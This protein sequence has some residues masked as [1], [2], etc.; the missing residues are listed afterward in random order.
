MNKF[1]THEGLVVPFDKSNID[2]DAIIPKQF[3][4][5][6]KRTGFGPH[7]FDELRYLDYGEPG[8]DHTQRKLNPNFILNQSRYYGASILLTRKNF[9]CG[10]SRE[11]ALWALYEYGFRAIIALSFA[12]IFMNNCFFNGLLP[13]VLS[14][15]E[16]EAL[17]ELVNTSFGLK[18]FINLSEQMISTKNLV[19]KFKIDAFCKYC[20]LNGLDS[21]SS[22]LRYKHKI[23]A[24]EQDYFCKY[25]W[26][27]NTLT[28][29]KYEL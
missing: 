8:I 27:V 21:V 4:K 10:S 25:P 23:L 22:T 20:L 13:I 19:Y 14:E 6:V 3:L 26:L 5:S 11:H 2:T 24:F 15:F 12:D 17:F 1:T 9:G 16:I 18:L 29:Q 28:E 7:L